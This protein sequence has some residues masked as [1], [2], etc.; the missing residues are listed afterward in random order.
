M[1]Q[2][3]SKVDDLD[4]TPEVELN[5]DFPGNIRGFLPFQVRAYNKLKDVDA[6]IM[7]MSTGT[8]K[9]FVSTG[10][11]KYHL[12]NNE[13]D[14]AIIAAKSH[15]KINFQR[16]LKKFGDLDSI[17]IDGGPKERK[18]VYQRIANSK[19][20]VI[21]ITNYEKFRIDYEQWKPIFEKRIELYLDEMP[22]KL[23]HRNTK[24][25]SRLRHLL[26]KKSLK[27]QRPEKLR[28]YMLTATPIENSPLDFYNCVRLLDPQV[29][30]SI[31]DFN[32]RYVAYFNP[33]SGEPER[34]RNLSDLGRRTE[35]MS[36]IVDKEDPE[37]AKQFPRVH[38]VE[39]VI[40]WHPEDLEIYKRL[41]QTSKEIFNGEGFESILPLIGLMQMMCDMPSSIN[42]SAK[43][44]EEYE[45]KLESGQLDVNR[46]GSSYAK[47]F[48]ESVGELYDDMHTKLGTLQELLA[49]RHP[50]E[51]VII[52]SSFNEALLPY[53][54]IAL[55]E[56]GISHVV[57]NGSSINKQRAQDKFQSEDGVRVF[58]SSDA[59][60]DSINLEKA[61]VV[62]HYDLP[63]K[64]S[65]YIQRQNRAHRVTSKW[66]HVT[67]YSLLMADSVDLRKS[68]I[69]QRKQKYH[70]ETFGH[71]EIENTPQ[72]DLLYILT[73]Q[74]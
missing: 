65:T 13:F 25:Y 18:K 58:L 47:L 74:N 56:W 11:L 72:K 71:N 8:G 16:F 20:P 23:K 69:I 45:K 64:W 53:L 9:S 21:V 36:V 38:E 4:A 49:E 10:L 37:I 12:Q 19:S 34:W 42:R 29:L 41:S 62:I 46:V 52:F 51:K 43:R 2:Q 57:Y 22:T 40:D 50:T 39:I 33:Y 28:Q 48:T 54:S 26:Y 35:H 17:V 66:G 27:E 60:S 14:V 70:T 15:N 59:G 68:E 3:L 31:A 73:G 63:L 55:T 5:S 24:L 67:F 61:S 6:G 30:G 44:Y 1:S 32:N 7:L